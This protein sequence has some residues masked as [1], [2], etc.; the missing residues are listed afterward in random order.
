[1]GFRITASEAAN[2][3]QFIISNQAYLCFIEHDLVK[4]K[5]EDIKT[6]IRSAIQ[7]TIK[8]IEEATSLY[9]KA[10]FPKPIG[11]SVEKDIISEDPRVFSDQQHLFF[12]QMM[13]EYGT[14][15]YGIAL[16]KTTTPQVISF[17]FDSINISGRL[18]QTTTELIE[19][20]GFAQQP[21]YIPP[22]QHAEM[23]K[24]QSFLGKFWG[25]ERPVNIME[26]DNLVY[27]LRGAILAKNHFMAFSQLAQDPDV[28]DFFV[29]GKDICKR[30]VKLLQS[31]LTH[32]DLPFQSTYETEVTDTTDSPYS[33][34]LMMFQALALAQMAVVRYG[35]AFSAN[36]RR[37]LAIMY[38]RLVSE[39][40]IFNEDGINLMINREWF[41]QPPLAPDREKLANK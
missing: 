8:I 17:L 15:A 26:I 23:I 1:V 34:R 25:E 39:T 13:A 29:R 21:I 7:D 38:S 31:V 32:E 5:D 28:R 9:V 27:S 11:F 14:G 40:V 12:L 37:D 4:T 18:Y 3:W 30:R 35:L 22:P 19:K 36:M 33:D 16:G 2:L 10:N 6:M 41:E 20:K 24:K